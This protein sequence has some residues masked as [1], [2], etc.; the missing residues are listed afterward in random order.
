M[1]SAFIELLNTLQMAANQ[2]LMVV[3]PY[4]S[5]AFCMQYAT[6]G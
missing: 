2:N 1:A 3:F 6:W 5:R 4:R